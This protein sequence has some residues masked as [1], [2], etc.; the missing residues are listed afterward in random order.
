MSRNR[1]V[2]VIFGLIVSIAGSWCSGQVRPPDPNEHKITDVRIAAFPP[3]QADGS[4]K[5]RLAI[6]GEKLPAEE[7]G[8][9]VLFDTKDPAR[10]VSGKVFSADGKEVLVDAV[11]TP[12][13]EITRIRLMW[14]EQ[15]ADT[16]SEFTISVAETA[17][18]KIDQFEIKLEHEKN[19]EFPNLHVLVLTKS[20]EDGGF[21]DNP[22]K[23]SVD[24]MPS[25]ASDVNIVQSSSQQLDIHFVA[26][27]DYVPTSAVVTVYN[28]TDLDTR[29][30]IAVAKKAGADPNQPKVTSTDVVFINRSQ[31]I[32]RIRI[33]GQGFG[34][35]GR[36]PY[37]VDDYLWNCLEEFHIRATTTKAGNDDELRDLQA[38][39]PACARTVD[40]N[41]ASI[42]SFEDLKK[43]LDLTKTSLDAFVNSRNPD[44]S[45]PW[46]DWKNKIRSAV[47]VSVNS[48]NPDIRVERVE[49]LDVNDKMIDVYFEFTRYR[50]YAWPFRLGDGTVMITKKNPKTAQ[51]VKN[52]KLT[53]TVQTVKPE[54]YSVAYQTGPP[55]SP[56]LTYQYTVLD[57]KSANTLVGKGIAENFWV[58]KLSVVNTGDKKVSVPLSAIQAE[59]EWVR[60]EDKQTAD[61]ETTKQI[62]Y[63]AGPPTESPVALGAVSAYFDAYQKVKGPRAILFNTLD[64]ATVMVTA[65]VP[66]TGPS[67]KDA[68]VFFSGGFIPGLRKAFGDLSSQ[69]LQNLTS[70]SWEGNETIAA[71]GGAAEKFIYIQK[72]DQF[73]GPSIKVGNVSHETRQQIASIMGLEITG[74]EID[75]ST[76]KT[77]TPAD[78]SAQPA[79]T[80]PSSQSGQTPSSPTTSTQGGS[81]PPN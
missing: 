76:T 8:V 65:L 10:T 50:G 40:G 72:Y 16:K 5:F 11:A 17:K 56:H 33:L 24:L 39:L 58:M 14:D 66:F 12:K 48:R 54:T 32:G 18:P 13:T 79:T 20:G 67:V 59:V 81:T 2:P 64:A 7:S 52:D 71:K 62:S 22:H 31:G 29:K 1:L 41:P 19:K 3:P 47:S 34:E 74:F 27:A 37:V 57:K 68:E 36:P 44:G 23:M 46:V 77:A 35:Y 43:N 63:M 69:Q 25:G 38:K 45:K 4:M 73:R 49:I 21:E 60:G 9:T 30:A 75:E 6:E 53:A 51:T 61:D 26:A 42:A 15:R 70:L 55:R 78:K 80:S 28:S